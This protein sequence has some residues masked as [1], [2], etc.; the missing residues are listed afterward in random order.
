MTLWA[1]VIWEMISA[2]FVIAAI[3]GF[4]ILVAIQ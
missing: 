2:V 1:I 3:L 4:V